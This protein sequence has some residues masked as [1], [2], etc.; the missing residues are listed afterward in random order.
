MTA[1]ATPRPGAPAPTDK[2]LVDYEVRDGLAII[3]LC[4]A[5][6]MVADSLSQEM[7]S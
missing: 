7:E 2:V 3:S 5:V 1:T 4:V 6:A